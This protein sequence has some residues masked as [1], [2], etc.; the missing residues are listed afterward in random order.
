MATRTPLRENERSRVEPSHGLLDWAEQWAEETGLTPEGE[1]AEGVPWHA[2]VL[3]VA[4][5]AL[6]KAAGK[7]RAL[8]ATMMLAG[9]R[10]G[11][12]TALRWRNV[13]LAGGKLRV[14]DSKT[15]AGVRVVDLS[16]DLL[17]DLKV[18]KADSERT[19]PEGLVFGT[20]NGTERNRSNITRQILHP[21]IERANVALKKAGRAPIEGATNHSLRRTFA[22]LLY[23]AGATPAYVMQQMGHTEASLALE[24]YSKVMER[25]RDTGERMDALIRGADW[26]TAEAP[27]E[28]GLTNSV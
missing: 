27:E 20:A 28:A 12:L 14:E 22:S 5:L 16:P 23:E 4:G 17:D 6:L 7:Y 24:V 26:E 19:S 11:E 13:D 15:D 25:K 2:V 18:H 1:P 9:L 21:A 10:V 8:I 3:N